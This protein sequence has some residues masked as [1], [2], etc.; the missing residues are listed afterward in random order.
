MRRRGSEHQEKVAFFKKNQRK[1]PASLGGGGA[2]CLPRLGEVIWP[3]SQSYEKSYRA[4][5]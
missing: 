1:S 2:S 3:L 4:E 5:L